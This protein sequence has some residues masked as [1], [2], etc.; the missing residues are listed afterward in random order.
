MRRPERDDERICK[1]AV[2]CWLSC[3]SETDRNVQD[4]VKFLAAGPMQAIRNP[5]AHEPAV[6][7]PITRADCLDILSFLWFLFRKLDDAVRVSA[8]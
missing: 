2:A 7:W 6:D 8:R 4:D 5:T 3:E 1:E